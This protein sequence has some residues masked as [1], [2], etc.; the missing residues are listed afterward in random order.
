MGDFLPA[1]QAIS[2]RVPTLE[3]GMS[4]FR[5]IHRC[6]PLDTNSS[7]CNLLQCGHFS[8][9]SVAASSADELVGFISGY[10]VPERQ[11]TLFIWQVA[12]DESAR[13]CGLAS[14][15]LLHILNRPSCHGIR[16]LETTIT[17]D[18]QPSWGLFTR[19]AKRLDVEL[20]SSPWLD[21]QVHFDGQHDSESLVRIGP[22]TPDQTE[23]YHE[24]F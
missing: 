15:M 2:L 18:N 23:T 24:N 21:K 13:G 6:P 17:Q 4:V 10:I 5:L 1:S 8:A 7:Y 22:F 11:D 14:K 19:L 20:R 12:V 3:D 9:T 16:Y